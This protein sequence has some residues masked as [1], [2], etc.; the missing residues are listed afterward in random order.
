[1][2]KMKFLQIG[3]GS[4]G[5]RRIRCLLHNGIDKS[6]IFGFDP[7]ATRRKE[8]E[9]KYGIK[10]YKDF[11]AAFNEVNPDALIISTPP[12][13]HHEYFLFAAKHKKHFFVE[14]T[15]IDKGYKELEKLLDNSFVAAP[16]CTFRY[17]PAVKK[18]K[19]LITNNE[20]GKVLSFNYH[21]GL[22]LPDW[23]P[24]EDYRKVYFSKKETGGAREMFVFELVW[25]VDILRSKPIK[26]GGFVD[27]VS[28]LDMPADDVYSAVLQFDNNIIGNIAVD[29]LARAPFRTL[30]IIGSEG[31]LNWEWMDYEIKLY[32]AKDK[33][34]KIIKL[35]EGEKKKYDFIAEGTYREEIKY[36]LD[37]IAGKK[38]YPYTFQ[39][40]YQILQTLHALEKSSKTNKF[41]SL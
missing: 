14:A 4:M 19:E 11:Q 26:V 27:K 1:M 23:H 7:L 36:F 3:L 32:R 2:P 29:V 33:K 12:N 31:V 41:I 21:L 8:T 18:I 25:L 15:I 13:L 34:W 10:T 16:S 5:K 37:A 22:Y 30:R 40:D 35:K 9:E 6:Q 24:W 39:E 28:D 20:I 38:K 17:F